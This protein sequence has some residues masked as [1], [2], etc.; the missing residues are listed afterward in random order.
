MAQRMKAM[1]AE[2]RDEIHRL[3]RSSYADNMDD[4]P[5][6]FASIV[7]SMAMGGIVMRPGEFG[8]T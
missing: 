7:R 8:E 4:G 5:R 2:R 1:P 6:S 3:G